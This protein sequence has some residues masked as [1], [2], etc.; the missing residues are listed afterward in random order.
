LRKDGSYFAVCRDYINRLIFFTRV[1]HRCD[2]LASRGIPLGQN[3]QMTRDKTPEYSAWKRFIYSDELTA[4]DLRFAPTIFLG[5][6]SFTLVI[7]DIPLSFSSLFGR[8]LSSCYNPATSWD[9]VLSYS[10]CL[11]QSRLRTCPGATI[12]ARVLDAYLVPSRPFLQ[13]QTSLPPPLGDVLPRSR[14]EAERGRRF[15][16]PRRI[17]RVAS[18]PLTI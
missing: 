16:D 12:L 3:L 8:G 18:Q 6:H 1:N 10:G 4:N 13:S 7:D 5:T 15:A 2:A 9:N 11:L 17:L 14:A